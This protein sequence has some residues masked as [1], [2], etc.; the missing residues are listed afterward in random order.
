M[1]ECPRSDVR[2]G[3]RNRYLLSFLEGQWLV[4]AADQGCFGS[5]AG[6][7]LTQLV[8]KLRSWND[9]NRPLRQSRALIS[10]G[11][12]RDIPPRLRRWARVTHGC[13]RRRGLSGRCRAAPHIRDDQGTD[14]V[15]G[16]GVRCGLRQLGINRLVANGIHE[17][18]RVV[19]TNSMCNSGRDSTRPPGP[20]TDRRRILTRDASTSRLIK[21]SAGCV[22]AQAI[23]AHTRRR[24]TTLPDRTA[25]NSHRRAT[26]KIRF[27]GGAV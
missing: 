5:V 17:H 9:A 10:G 1:R 21:P 25:A 15:L 18:P 20:A 8:E 19:M 6:F 4:P 11:Q 24:D 27:E 13:C 26:E 22:C 12:E 16:H 7:A 2:P 14:D 23:A 3:R